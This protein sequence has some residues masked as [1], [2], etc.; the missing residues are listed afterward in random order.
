MKLC[1]FVINSFSLF[2]VK[3]FLIHSK[4]VRESLRKIFTKFWHFIFLVCFSLN[5]TKVIVTADWSPD[6]GSVPPMSCCHYT[7]CPPLTGSSLSQLRYSPGNFKNIST[8][9]SPSEHKIWP[10]ADNGDTPIWQES[11]VWCFRYNSHYITSSSKYHWHLLIRH[12][13]E[14]KLIINN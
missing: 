5:K 12:L 4:G 9:L 13:G 2:P 10:L 8:F 14:R 3:S 6:T 11:Q 1:I 7:N